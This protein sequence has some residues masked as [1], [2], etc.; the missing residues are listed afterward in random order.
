MNSN[1]STL[2]KYLSRGGKG[3]QVSQEKSF[4]HSS[5]VLSG[6]V[7]EPD[8][9]PVGGSSTGKFGAGLPTSSSP[10][11]LPSPPNYKVVGNLRNS[12]AEEEERGLGGRV[13]SHQVSLAARLPP[14]PL[15]D[16]QA[17]A[18]CRNRSP[19]GGRQTPA[20][21]AQR[22]GSPPASGL[23]GGQS[24]PMQNRSGDTSP[25]PAHAHAPPKAAL[26]APAAA[27]ISPKH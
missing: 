5:Y 24:R 6:L 7:L 16:R 11:S 19:E 1:L 26:P 12:C 3:T 9:S 22:P 27:R 10:P 23:R 2:Q 18:S 20:A 4:K 25:A 21:L 13:P 15:R 8:Q 17:G 14:A